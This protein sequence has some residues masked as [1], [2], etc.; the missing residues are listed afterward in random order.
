MA[1]PRSL[2]VGRAW[3]VCTGCLLEPH[4]SPQ[5]TGTQAESAQYPVKD[6]LPEPHFSDEGGRLG[7]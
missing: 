2:T 7:D 6:V 5:G 3:L 1:I 4:L